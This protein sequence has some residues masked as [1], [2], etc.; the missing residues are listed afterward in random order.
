V[1]NRKRRL[2][3][4]VA[5][6]Q[7]QHGSQIIH[8]GIGERAPRPEALKTGF[9]QLDEL[10][11][12]KG[13]PVGALTLISGK[14][15]NGKTTI[16]Y[17]LLAKTQRT[18]AGKAL[19]VALVDLQGL[20]NPDYLVRCGIDIDRIDV[21][22]IAPSAKAVHLILDLVR[23]GQ[24]RLI[25]VDSLTALTTDSKA[26][27]ALRTALRR[28][29]TL[30]RAATCA[31]VLLDD[32]T[33]LWSRSSNRDTQYDSWQ[34]IDMHLDLRRER[35]IKRD[36]SFI[37]YA[38]RVELKRSRWATSSASVVVEITFNGTVKAGRTW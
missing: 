27:K 6:L 9:D 17:K 7:Q 29:P 19:K 37:G 22:R 20:A 5:A 8:K 15:T 23:S 18:K 28:L 36:E 21:A 25:V 34:S 38:S 11:G 1:S 16:A 4:T 10:T 33:A 31:M 30:L 26:M 2:E 14:G 35:W 13:I 12:C 3:S 24:Y 32:P